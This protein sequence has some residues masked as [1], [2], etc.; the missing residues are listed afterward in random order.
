MSTLALVRH[1]QASFFSDNYDQLSPLGER[2][3]QLLGEYWVRRGVRFDEVFTGP[4]V[5]QMETAE[6]AGAAFVKAGLPWPKAQVLPELDEH[7]VDRLIKLAMAEIASEHPHVEPLHAAYRAAESPRDVHRTFQLLFEQIVMLW[8]AEK[9]AHGEVE[10]WG[11]FRERVLRGLSHIAAG[12][13]RGRRVAAFTSVGAVTVCL[14]AALD[15]PNRTAFD[16]G[17]RVR[18]ASIT[19]FLFSPGRLTLEGF[20]ACPHLEDPALVTFR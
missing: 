16:L 10:P 1:G 4:R 15:C 7:Q 2:Q 20:N 11:A 3:A 18:N 14:Q 19:D 12:E 13:A 8:V 17:W 9:V 5:R 6:L